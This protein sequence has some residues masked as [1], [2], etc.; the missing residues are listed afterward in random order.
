MALPT[1]VQ[2]EATPIANIQ[3]TN[4]TMCHFFLFLAVNIFLSLNDAC[5]TCS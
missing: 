2:K 5:V 1:Q 3:L 4:F